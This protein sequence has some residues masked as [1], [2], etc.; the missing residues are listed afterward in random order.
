MRKLVC[1]TLKIVRFNLIFKKE[2]FI[3]KEIN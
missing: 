1:K 3:K 2:S